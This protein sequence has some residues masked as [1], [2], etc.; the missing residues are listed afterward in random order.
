MQMNAATGGYDREFDFSQ[1]LKDCN[2]YLDTSEATG[3]DFLFYYTGTKAIPEINA[4]KCTTF[5]AM[6]SYSSVETIEK[7]ILN[8]TG[9]NQKFDRTFNNTSKLKNIEIEGCIGNN[10]DFKSCSKLTVESIRSILK[11]L[12]TNGSGKAI[13]L[14]TV[15]QAI[16]E[17]DTECIQYATAAKSAGWTFAYN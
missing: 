17:S 2:I 3:L 5:T 11:A 8:D 12:S 13:T 15:H 10:I 16:I 14:A 7:L 6:F 9:E 1:R 4:A